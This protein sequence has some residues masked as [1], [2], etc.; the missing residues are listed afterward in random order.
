MRKRFLYLACVLSLAGATTAQSTRYESLLATSAGRDSLFRLAMWEDGRVT[1]DGKLFDYLR[2]RNPLVRLRSVQVIGRIQDAQDAPHLIPLLK[3]PDPSVVI[4]TI[5]A[6][7]QLGNLE[8][9]PALVELA[10]KGAPD[11]LPAIADALGKIGGEEAITGLTEMLHA[12]QGPVR[13]GAALGLARVKD[14]AAVSP[15][16]VAIHDGDPAVS[17][18]AIYALETRNTKR[19]RDAVLPFLAKGDP[20]VRAYAARTLGKL[21]AEEAVA[22]LQTNVFD[23]DPRVAINS[24]NA[25]A[26]ILEDKK[27]QAATKQIGALIAKTSSHHVKKSAVTALGSIGHKDAKDVLAQTVLDGDPG[28]RGESYRA[29]AKVLGKASLTF[30]N[31]GRNDSSIYVRTAVVEAVGL[32]EDNEQ[33]PGL[34]ALAQ[35]SDDH[36]IRAA[37]VKALS[38]FKSDR[39]VEALV[40]RLADPDWVVATEAVI[41]LGA[42]ADKKCIPALVQRFSSREDHVDADIRLE[43]MGVLT[44]MKAAE[45]RDIAVKALDDRDPRLRRAAGDYFDALQLEKPPIQ[46]DRFYYER[47]FDPS[48]RA[49]LNPPM[50]MKKAILKTQRGDVTIE[51]FGDDATQTV[52]E[53]IRNTHAGIYKDGVFH[54][55]V[56]N[57]VVQGGCPRGDGSG[58]AG[59]YI[60]AEV[61]RHTYERGMVGIADSGKDTGGTQFFITHSPQPHLNG[62][63][64]IFGRVTSGMDAVDR[65]A[66]GDRFSVVIVE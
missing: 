37:A 47:D 13:G 45:G 12:F 1:G 57:F 20:V 42:V 36:F 8:A 43:I 48:R 25:L 19:V 21:K 58:D 52:A 30:V 9:S 49:G 64:T 3:D 14:E 2:S 65:I 50:G 27:D 16:L 32:T 60:R 11:M 26:A 56:P 4:E 7:G 10:R 31:G 18:R 53:F 61:N 66:Q 51:L 38:N 35:D 6:L 29:M 34:I 39:V 59:H 40:A 15:L 24:I 33:I 55:V 41:A 62:R 5:F 22:A 17:W 54:R 23:A 28:I 44:E 63:Y 46:N